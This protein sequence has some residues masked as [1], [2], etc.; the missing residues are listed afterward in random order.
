MTPRLLLVEDEPSLVR[1][2]ADSFRDEGYDVRFVE[3]GDEAS[4][5]FESSN[6][7]FSFSTSFYRAAP[8]STCYESFVPR[9]HVYRY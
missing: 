9:I 3:R 1:G 5:R 6:P 2:L 7:T 4:P 8:G